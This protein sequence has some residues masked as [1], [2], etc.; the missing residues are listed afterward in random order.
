MREMTVPTPWGP[1]MIRPNKAYGHTVAHSPVLPWFKL[2]SV[3]VYRTNPKHFAYTV[4][5][6]TRKDA[7]CIWIGLGRK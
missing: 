5:I 7:R 3:K 1:F 4:W 2:F 6:Y